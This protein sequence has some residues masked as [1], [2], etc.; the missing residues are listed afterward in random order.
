MTVFPL[1]AG[2]FLRTPGAD[3]PTLQSHFLPALSS[4]TL[5][6]NPFRKTTINNGPGF[7]ANASLMR[8]LSRAG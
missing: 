4:A 7:M 8:P 1:E 3:L 5:R 2:A 6:V